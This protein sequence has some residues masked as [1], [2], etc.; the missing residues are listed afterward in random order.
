MPKKRRGSFSSIR[1]W[2][3]VPVSFVETS[4]FSSIRQR[5]LV[6]ERF[7]LL[8]VAL[9]TSPDAGPVI[10]GT[11]GIR[12]LRWS[13]E[14][15]GKRGGLRIL[16]YWI[17]G[18]D[19]IYLLNIYKKAEMADLTRAELAVLRKLVGKIENSNKE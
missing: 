7:R 10:K 18:K 4:W 15:A 6:D 5:Y 14:G 13:I 17:P 2:R 12:K 3:I 16:Y 9:M 8:Q 19:T 11:G 1:Q